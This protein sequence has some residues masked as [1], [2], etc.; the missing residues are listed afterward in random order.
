MRQKA[1]WS[2]FGNGCFSSSFRYTATD[3]W[4]RPFA[5][6]IKR[7]VTFDELLLLV[8][9]IVCGVDGVGSTNGHAGSTIDAAF[10]FNIKLGGAFKCCFIFLGMNAICWANIHAKHILDAS[11][12]NYVGHDELSSIN[13]VWQRNGGLSVAPQR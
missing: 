2:D 12:S 6:V 10:G 1:F 3:L 9:Q 13:L 4:P 8:A 7:G 5:L 11:I